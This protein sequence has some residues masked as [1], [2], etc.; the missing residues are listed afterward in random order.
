MGIQDLVNQAVKKGLQVHKKK[1]SSGAPVG[2]SKKSKA[3]KKAVTA[4]PTKKK[5]SKT[6][7]GRMKKPKEKQRV[8][9][10]EE[11]KEKRKK[12]KKIRLSRLLIDEKPPVPKIEAKKKKKTLRQKDEPLETKMENPISAY[13]PSAEEIDH[14]ITLRAIQGTSQESSVLHDPAADAGLFSADFL[15]MCAENKSRESQSEDELLQKAHRYFSSLNKQEQKRNALAARRLKEMKRVNRAGGDKDGFRYVVPK[16]VTA[17][18]RQLMA[19]EGVEGANID[20]ETLQSH[21]GGDGVKETEAKPMR[22]RKAKNY[23]FDDFYQ[24]QVAK[25]WTK[26]AE[27]FLARGRASKNMFAA[28][29]KQM[30]SI[31]RM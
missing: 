20:P 3:G 16:N 2:E 11:A 7:A 17:V 4:A 25:K 12:P 18:V 28:K 27:S 19:A 8:L 13:M 23:A 10:E 5:A 6:N 24:F 1:V 14:L 22:S 21:F 9:Y 29:Q 26:N 30:R 15:K 31:K